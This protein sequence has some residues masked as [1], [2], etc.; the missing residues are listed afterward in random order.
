MKYECL[1]KHGDLDAETINKNVVAYSN[2]V[3]QGA[4]W[5]PLLFSVF[6]AYTAINYKD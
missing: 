6:F 2:G 5:G 4:V 3:L 1:E